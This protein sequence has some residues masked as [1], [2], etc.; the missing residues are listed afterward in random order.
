LKL[1]LNKSFIYLVFLLELKSFMGKMCQSVEITL[2]NVHYFQYVCAWI[3]FE[4][5]F[6]MEGN[7]VLNNTGSS[8]NYNSCYV[9]HRKLKN[10][11]STHNIL[12]FMRSR[13]GLISILNL[14]IWKNL[15][16]W[17]SQEFDN[18]HHLKPD[19]SELF[20]TW[21]YGNANT[22]EKRLRMR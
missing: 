1:A 11:W 2:V 5:V 10:I 21:V 14:F 4:K 9:D 3:A 18:A 6:C 16:N 8:L 22:T 17:I 20:F 19:F 13:M 7:Y 12:D 15:E